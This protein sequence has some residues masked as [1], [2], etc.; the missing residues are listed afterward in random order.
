MSDDDRCIHERRGKVELS[1]YWPQGHGRYRRVFPSKPLARKMRSIIE[2]AIHTNTWQELRRQLTE[3]PEPCP[4]FKEFVDVFLKHYEKK[5]KRVDFAREEVHRFLPRIGNVALKDFTRADAVR[6][7]QWRAQSVSGPTVNRMMDVLSS[8]LS[9]ALDLEHISTHPMLR[10]PSYPEE[11][12]ALRVMTVD[13]ARGFIGA[14]LKIDPVV[15]VYAGVMG[16]LGLRPSEAERLEWRHVDLEERILTVDRTKGKRPR[17]VPISDFAKD[18]F[19]TLPRLADVPFC[20]VRLETFKPVQ[21]VRA[22]FE[23]AR[24]LTG[25]NWVNPEDFRHYRATQWVR[26]GIDLKTVQSLL[27]HADIHTTMR[28]AHFAPN[29]AARSIV[30]A[31]RQEAESLRQLTMDF[32]QDQNRTVEVGELERLMALSEAKS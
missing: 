26:Q 30:E 32:R 14:L 10:F 19:G 1:M 25:M 16:E 20:F 8:M 21:D 5:N 29:H 2:A 31:Q 3:K 6:L 13:E 27:G 7:Q 18:L 23:K 22:P 24:V 12:R 28:Y 4:T 11:P 15:G 9:H 17:Y